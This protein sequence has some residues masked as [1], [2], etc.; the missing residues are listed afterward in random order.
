MTTCDALIERIENALLVNDGNE[1]EEAWYAL[2]A[3]HPAKAVRV[4]QI[5]KPLAAQEAVPV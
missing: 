4:A 1:L 2:Y 5:M 3:Q